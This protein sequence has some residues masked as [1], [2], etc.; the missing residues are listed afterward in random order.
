MINH[1]ETEF[2]LLVTKEKFEQLSALY[3]EKTFITQ[4]NTYYDTPDLSLKQKKC[5]M[6]I[7][8]IA[9]ACIFTLKTPAANG[10]HEYECEVSANDVSV[11]DEP[12]IR[13]LLEELGIE[14]SLVSI[15]S[16]KTD[17]AVINTGKAELCF[18]INEYHGQTD[19]EIEYEQLIDH[20]GAA[21]FNEILASVGLHYEKNCPSKI[22]R[23]MAAL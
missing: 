19:Y 2:K 13:K 20:D 4:V 11:F 18:D 17:R 14:G 8:E 9:G 1:I 3:P 22:A 23:A 6:R 16:L 5:A 10:H 21:C 12:S 7:R 15:A